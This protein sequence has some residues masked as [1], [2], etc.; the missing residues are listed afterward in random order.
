MAE[1]STNMAE[2]ALFV[3]S[4]DQSLLKEKV[5][6]YDW[7]Q[8][9]DYNKLLNS[10]TQTGFQATS[11]GLAVDEINRMIKCRD[12]PIPDDKYIDTDDE[13]TTVRN[14][15]TIFLGYTSNMVSSGIRETIKF[16]VQHQMVD[17][18]VTTAGGIEED[19]IKCLAPTF[20]GD[21]SLDGKMLRETVGITNF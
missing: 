11:F 12:L 10:Y 17:C 6:G 9:L 7:S 16:L 14:S 19:F 1:H 18:L 2:E 21:F 13:F 20:L 3:K 4:T 5:I 8:G 15:C